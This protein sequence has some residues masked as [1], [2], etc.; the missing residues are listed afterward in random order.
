MSELYI[1]F[2]VWTEEFRGDDDAK[3]FAQRNKGTVLIKTDDGRTVWKAE[4]CN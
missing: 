2:R 4:P 1:V 3:E